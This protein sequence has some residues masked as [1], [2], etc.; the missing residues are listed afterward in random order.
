MLALAPWESL[1]ADDVLVLVPA[2]MSIVCALA[3]N[4]PPAATEEPPV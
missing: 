4:V 2:S 1:L 3:P